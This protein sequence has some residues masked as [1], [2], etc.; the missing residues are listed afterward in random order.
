MRETICQKCR[1]SNKKEAVVCNSCGARL[2]HAEDTAFARLKESGFFGKLAALPFRIIKFLVKKIYWVLSIVLG[3]V[4]IGGSLLLIFMFAPLSWPDYKNPPQSDITAMAAQ[5]SLT[6][7]ETQGTAR[8]TIDT[9]IKLGNDFLTAKP[10]KQSNKPAPPP[11]APNDWI[12]KLKVSGQ[13]S[14]IKSGDE[15]YEFT[16]VGKIN[17]KL[18]WRLVARFEAD[19]EKEGIFLPNGYRF[20]SVPIPRIIYLRL[21]RRIVP[22]INAD[23]Q[24]LPWLA[25]IH[26]A[27]MDLRNGRNGE[28]YLSVEPSKKKY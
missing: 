22:M 4:L 13:F 17:E 26:N 5:T 7:L 12:S 16:L 1:A 11:A 25:R 10:K 21:L 27:K 19:R 24:L 28:F 9:V 15:Q 18:P 14:A 8:L 23:Q 6:E 3:T 20:G 2:D